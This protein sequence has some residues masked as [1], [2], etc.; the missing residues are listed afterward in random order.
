MKSILIF[1]KW[2][3]NVQNGLVKN[4]LV[5]NALTDE[6]FCID[7]EI[8]WSQFKP[9]LFFYDDIFLYFFGKRTWCNLC[10]YYMT[11]NDNANSAKP[12]KKYVCKN[13]DKS[14]NDRAGLWRHSKKCVEPDDI[15][16]VKEKESSKTQEL[17]MMIIDEFRKERDEFTPLDI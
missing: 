10:C 9:F 16:D 4:G 2:T 15:E 5:K 17:M 1:E 6:N 12:S 14:F 13:C 11:T 7:R 3:K 8:L